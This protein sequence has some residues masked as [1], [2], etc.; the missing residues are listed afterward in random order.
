M[1]EIPRKS[2]G[3][4]KV[5]SKEQSEVAKE[6][7]GLIGEIEELKRLQSELQ[8]SDNDIEKQTEDKTD[9]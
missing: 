7:H 3:D 9:Q 4:S 5:V 1:K 6:L 2:D 8:N